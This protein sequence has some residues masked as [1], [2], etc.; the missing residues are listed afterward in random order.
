MAQEDKQSDSIVN[1]T[2][3]GWGGPPKR[4]IVTLTQPHEVAALRMHRLAQLSAQERSFASPGRYPTLATWRK[5]DRGDL[6]F[7]TA[8][9]PNSCPGYVKP[10]EDTL[11]QGAIERIGVYFFSG[12]N[13][14]ETSAFGFATPDWPASSPWVTAV[15]GTSLGIDVAKA[16]VPE[17]RDPLSSTSALNVLMPPSS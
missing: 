14:D 10:F 11:I 8:F 2:V 13:G 5:L 4:P 12:D 17:T 16:R 3:G 15:G 7:G 1:L 9:R 6:Q